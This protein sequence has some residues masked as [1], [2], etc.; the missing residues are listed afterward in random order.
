MIRAI[1]LILLIKRIYNL[2]FIINIHIWPSYWVHSYNF[3]FIFL[4]CEFWL[5]F[6][7][8]EFTFPSL[9]KTQAPLLK[10]K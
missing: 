4:I 8:S 3:F 5:K 2:D 7:P 9:F 10:V 6:F 1:N